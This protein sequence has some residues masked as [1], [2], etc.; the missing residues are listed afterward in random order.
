MEFIKFHCI[1]TG[2][3]FKIIHSTGSILKF[4][5]FLR[6]LQYP[7]GE[8]L[9]MDYNS[10]KIL[11]SLSYVF[12]RCSGIT[13]VSEIIGILSVSPVQRGTT[14]KCMWDSMPAP[15]TLPK[16]RP[17]LNPSGD[18]TFFKTSTDSF[19]VLII[20]NSTSSGRPSNVGV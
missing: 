19:T 3:R 6:R 18:K 4:L 15:A 11:I 8:N 5:F 14:C 2:Y 16:F 13:L 17:I 9:F 7:G 1:S 10:A 12:L 20:S